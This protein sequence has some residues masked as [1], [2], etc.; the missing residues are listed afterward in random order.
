MTFDPIAIYEQVERIMHVRAPMP[1]I[2]IGEHNSYLPDNVNTS[3]DEAKVTVI[4]NTCFDMNLVH[5]FSHHL[6]VEGGKLAGV[7]NRYVKGVLAEIALD[8]ETRFEPWQPN[9]I[10]EH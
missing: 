4:F 1:L 7:E 5:E 9:C 3:Y 2:E 6:A 10:G 8:V